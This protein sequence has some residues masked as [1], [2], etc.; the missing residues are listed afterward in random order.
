LGLGDFIF[1]SVL[2]GKAATIDD[3]GVVFA[4][5]VS[6]IVG[7][8]ATIFI[9]AIFQRPLPVRFAHPI[10]PS[11]LCHSP[12]LLFPSKCLVQVAGVGTHT[13]AWWC[14]MHGQ[15]ALPISIFLAL[16]FFFVSRVT[17]SLYLEDIMQQQIYM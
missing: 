5:Y 12:A 10:V 4:S 2:V 11:F 8:C 3:W 7:L 1:Y 13:H 9:L 16:F 6:I 15:Q 14:G 17:M